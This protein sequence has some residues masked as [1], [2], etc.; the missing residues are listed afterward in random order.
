MADDQL[1]G[2]KVWEGEDGEYLDWEGGK[3]CI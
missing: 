3:G 2:M 1:G